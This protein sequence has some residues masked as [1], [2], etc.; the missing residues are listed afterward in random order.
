MISDKDRR[1]LD[2][3]ITIWLVIVL[4][5]S[6][7]GGYVAFLVWIFSVAGVAWTAAAMVLLVP[8]PGFA[9]AVASTL[10]RD[11]IFDNDGSPRR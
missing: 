7:F 8:V 9:L 2:L 10:V 6:T 11:R 3:G 4:V 1:R 5:G